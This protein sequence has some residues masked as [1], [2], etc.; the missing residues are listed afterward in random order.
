MVSVPPS[1]PRARRSGHTHGAKHDLRG[2][3]KRTAWTAAFC[4]LRALSSS[5]R[6]RGH[7]ARDSSKSGS[8]G[9]KNKKKERKNNTRTNSFFL[10]EGLTVRVR[11]LLAAS[12]RHASGVSHP[13]RRTRDSRSV[14]HTCAGADNTAA[15]SSRVSYAVPRSSSVARLPAFLPSARRVG[16]ISSRDARVCCR[17]AYPRYDR[18]YGRLPVGSRAL[19]SRGAAYGSLRRGSSS[20]HI[21]TFLHCFLLLALPPSPRGSGRAVLVRVGTPLKTISPV[22]AASSCLAC[23]HAV[24]C[25]AARCSDAATPCP[26]AGGSRPHHV[27]RSPVHDATPRSCRCRCFAVRRAAF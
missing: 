15:D 11:G 17:G 19:P 26:Q 5:A 2:Q 10:R 25:L 14:C 4:P 18:R 13:H 1:P 22:R 24:R 23:T 7:G 16:H 27:V 9:A 12:P 20:S 8:R 21:S 6:R 3:P